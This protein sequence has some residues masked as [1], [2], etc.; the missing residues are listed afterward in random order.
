MEIYANLSN[1]YRNNFKEAPK[2]RYLK[3]ELTNI[4]NMLLKKGHNKPEN[5]NYNN[6]RNIFEDEK[7]Y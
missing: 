1:K 6:E 3:I 2:A 7:D 5:D 4:I